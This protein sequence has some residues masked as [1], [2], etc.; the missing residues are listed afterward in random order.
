MPDTGKRM[1]AEALENAWSRFAHDYPQSTEL[2]RAHIAA[3][4]AELAQARQDVP[5]LL[6]AL[7]Q[8]RARIIELEDV[9]T[10]MGIALAHG[11]I[12]G[13]SP[14]EAIKA[15]MRIPEK[16]MPQSVLDRQGI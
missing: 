1:S 9:I 3:L 4:D 6:A 10:E 7:K 2:V 8:A 5:D 12:E 14:L 16:V 11:E 13:E 15:A